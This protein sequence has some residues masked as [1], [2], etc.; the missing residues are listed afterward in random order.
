MHSLNERRFK[1]GWCAAH[2]QDFLEVSVWLN[3]G[4][5]AKE[6]GAE[7]GGGSVKVRQQC[8]QYCRHH[9]LQSPS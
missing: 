6:E 3:G 9:S 1:W 2:V 5:E 4:A 7:G 8:S